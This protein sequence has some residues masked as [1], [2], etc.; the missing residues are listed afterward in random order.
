MASQ[1][2]AADPLSTTEITATPAA[3]ITAVAAPAGAP[4]GGQAAA[5]A[6]PP[7]TAPA[8]TTAPQAPGS[9]EPIVDRGDADIPQE[10]PQQANGVGTDGETNIWEARYSMK[11]FLGRLVFWSL[12]AVGWI[13][14]AV[15]TWVYEHGGL[16]I[17]AVASG[18]V[19]AIAWL[20]LGRRILLARYGHYYR[21]TNRRVFVSTGLFARRRDQMELLRVQ[22]VFT[23][24]TLL[25]RW[26][27]VGTVVIVSHEAALPTLY[28]TGVDNPKFVM[29]LVW[30]HA[31]A[32]RDRRSVKVDQI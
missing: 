17:L 24:Q 30:H 23:R 29:D 2:P 8:P 11:N 10:T 25:Q 3:P 9:P 14:L 5:P 18:I 13:V 31:R 4:V 15:Y 19:L 26:L 1:T 27:S 28:L 21:L 12:A 7:T 16:S 22:D 20:A 6:Q 32:E